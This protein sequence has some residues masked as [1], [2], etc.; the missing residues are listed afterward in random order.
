MYQNST[1]VTET[2]V[3]TK[4]LSATKTVRVVSKYLSK[5]INQRNGLII[6]HIKIITPRN[7]SGTEKT[8]SST[9]SSNMR[10]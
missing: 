8:T 2:D 3:Y 5:Q 9:V 7:D 4:T 10:H 1:F 6:H